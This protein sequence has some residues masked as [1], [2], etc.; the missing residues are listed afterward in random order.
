MQ[1]K[2]GHEQVEMPLGVWGRQ[3]GLMV[4][5]QSVRGARNSFDNV[6]RGVRRQ[7]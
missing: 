3:L 1:N 7:M 2:Q 4:L 6:R 5:M